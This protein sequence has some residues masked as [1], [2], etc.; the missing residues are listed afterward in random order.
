MAEKLKLEMDEST[1]LRDVVY[2]TLRHA[3]LANQ[4][5]PGTRLYE[6]HLADELG[7]SRT[8]VREAIQKLERD[9][10]V[11]MRA[12]RGVEVAPI[13]LTQMRDV[14]ELR[15][16]LDAL[17]AELACERATDEDISIVE[18]AGVQFRRALKEGNL[19]TIIE[20]DTLYHGSIS[21]ASHNKRLQEINR[22]MEDQVNRYRYETIKHFSDHSRL[23][24]EHNDILEAIKA[25]DKE[26]AAA[27]ARSHIS[28][29]MDSFLE[30]LSD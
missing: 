15:M 3:I 2:N 12:K 10:L 30:N 27:T 23:V 1:P 20:K 7:V 26:K 17:A 25:H 4:L 11:V 24:K 18:D 22:E 13:T 9:G 21:A 8:P 6:V 28:W 16:I 5:P 14:L 29:Q 19:H